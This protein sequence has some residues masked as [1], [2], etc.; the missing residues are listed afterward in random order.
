MIKTLLAIDI[1]QPALITYLLERLPE[2]YD[3][4]EN[5]NSSSCTAR[6]ILHQLRWSEY[7]VEPQALTGKLI[8]PIVVYLKELMDENIELT[9]PIL[10]ALSN[11]TLN[12]DSLE[13]VREIVLNRLDSAEL[14]DLAVII[15]FLLQTVNPF[16]VDQVIFGIREKLDFRSLGKSTMLTLARKPKHSPEALILDSI[17]LGFESHKYICDSWLKSIAALETKPAHKIID[18]LVLIILHSMASMKKKA[19]ALLRKKIISGLITSPLIQETILQHA[20]G[21]AGYWDTILSLS[22][23]LLRSSEQHSVVI[24]CSSILYTCAFKSSDAYYRQEIIGSL[25]THIGSGSISFFLRFCY[26]TYHLNLSCFAYV[27]EMDVSL[28]TLLHL[29]KTDI[30]NMVVYD[31]FIKG[32]LDYLDSLTLLQIRTLFNIFSLLSLTVGL[33]R[34]KY[35]D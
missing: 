5:D 17:K 11:L 19:E 10:D 20:D 21:L 8:E 31:I 28:D 13:G 3:E 22:E 2:F 29:A 16:T 4:L 1:I 35:T 33:Q 32:I 6:L 26:L 14:D 34:C 18:V 7:I 30:E 23:S 15:K 24:P 9:A 27:T 25:V 12:N